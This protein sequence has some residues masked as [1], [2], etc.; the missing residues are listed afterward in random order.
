MEEQLPG[1][2]KSEEKETLL[3]W[4]SASRPFKKRSREYW[5][6]LVII[7]LL[8]SLI[9]FFFGQYA[10]ILAVWALS[11][12]A[13]VLSTVPPHDVDHKI[14]NQGI[15]IGEHAYL[16]DELYDFYFRKRFGEEVLEVRGHTALP[17]LLTITLGPLSK[18]QIKEAL[19]KYLPYREVVERTFM[20][21]AGDWLARTFPLE[22]N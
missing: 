20:D 17:F 18:E 12:L 5:A 11:F 6:T 21:K 7:V 9:L 4:R 19:I 10:L 15:V 1:S 13:I 16:W 14:T 8:I 3:Y 2:L 22:K